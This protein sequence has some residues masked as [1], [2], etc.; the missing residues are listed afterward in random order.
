MIGTGRMGRRHIDV[1]R[2]AGLE[3]VGICDT[4]EAALSAAASE[5]DVASGQQFTDTGRLLERT[6]PECVV[7]ATTAPA[8]CRYTLAAAQAGVQYILCEKPMGVSLAQCDTM[9]TAC[10]ERKVKLAVNHQ[11]RFM[12]QYAEVKR[13]VQSESFGDRSSVTVVGGNFGMAM[14]G[15]HYFEMF[16]Y[17]TG[18]AA[19][20]VSAWLSA[21]P[22]PNSRGREFE[23]SAT[24]VRVTT[25]RGKRF[26]LEAG[27]N[28][29]HGVKVICAGRWG[30]IVVDE[31]AGTMF[32]TVREADYRGLPTTRYGM[33]SIVTSDTI[34]PADVITPTRAVLEALVNDGE[35]PNGE[36]GRLN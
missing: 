26:Y 15:T 8:H 34:L 33:P 24:A 27:S 17:M 9:I 19:L 31:L 32:T 25:A 7:V 4:N 2:Q 23:D 1:L 18:E 30:Q 11:M 5:C 22:V 36:D 10:H 21:D 12:P 29:G 6:R 20:D 3:L 13:L 35:F 28:Q 14:N 16:R